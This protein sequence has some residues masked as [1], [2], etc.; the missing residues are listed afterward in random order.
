MQKEISALK[1]RATT[2]TS[3]PPVIATTI[4]KTGEV[5]DDVIDKQPKKVERGLALQVQRCLLNPRWC[6]TPVKKSNKVIRGGLGAALPTAAPLTRKTTTPSPLEMA[7]RCVLEGGCP[8]QVRN[9]NLQPEDQEE[10]PLRPSATLIVASPPANRGV[11]SSTGADEV[12]LRVRLCLFTNV[13]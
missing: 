7:K 11:L 9:V 2:T 8:E 10:L 13:C 3:A 5:D 1:T 4:Q 12:A 6:G